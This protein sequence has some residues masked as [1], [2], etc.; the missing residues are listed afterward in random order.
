MPRFVRRASGE[1]SDR[2]VRI[3][4]EIAQISG[5][6]LGQQIRVGTIPV[7]LINTA[8]AVVGRFN[9]MV[10]DQDA[11]DAL[12]PDR[13]FQARSLP[14]DIPPNAGKIGLS[15]GHSGDPPPSWRHAPV[16]PRHVPACRRVQSSCPTCAGQGREMRWQPT[17]AAESEADLSPGSGSCRCMIDDLL[18]TDSQDH[19]ERLGPLAAAMRC[20]GPHVGSAHQPAVGDSRRPMTP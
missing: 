11:I 1:S 20:S 13:T 9:P 4:Q 12:V 10:K 7:G 18:N 14:D 16:P 5:R 15:T 3:M 19:Q 8:A 17:C 6:L 2:G